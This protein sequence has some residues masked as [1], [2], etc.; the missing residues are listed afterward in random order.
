MAKWHHGPSPSRTGQSCVILTASVIAPG[1]WMK[2][3]EQEGKDP[4]KEKEKLTQ[5]ALRSK[6]ESNGRVL[7]NFNCY[8][9]QGAGADHSALGLEIPWVASRH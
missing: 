8:R 3:G 2:R 1:E 9:I 6:P 7:R 5:K 4:E